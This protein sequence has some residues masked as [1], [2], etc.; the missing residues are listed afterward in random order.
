LKVKTKALIKF[1]R[2]LSSSGHRLPATGREKVSGASFRCRWDFVDLKKISE[3]FCFSPALITCTCNL[4]LPYQAGKNGY[5]CPLPVL[6]EN[7][8][9]LSKLLRAATGTEN[10][11]VT[12]FFLPLSSRETATN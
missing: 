8:I 2:A 12:R 5:P 10:R 4:L 7:W 1:F 3:S 6:R 11:H 9:D